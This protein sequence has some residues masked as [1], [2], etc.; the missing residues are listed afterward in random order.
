MS[1]SVDNVDLFTGGLLEERLEKGVVGPT[2]G[3]IIAKQFFSLKY[4]DRFYFQTD[5]EAEGFT[6][7]Q[8]SAIRNVTLAKVCCQNKAAYLGGG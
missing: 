8:L 6:D 1:R 5:R 3:C 4:G 2:F 7:A